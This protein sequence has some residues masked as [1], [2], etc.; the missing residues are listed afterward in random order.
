MWLPFSTAGDDVPMDPSD[1]LIFFSGASRIP[2][3]GFDRECTLS[4]N[5][6][7][8]YPTA[9]TCALE[10]TLPT[11]YHDD[12]IHFKDKMLYAFAN[13]GGFGLC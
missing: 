1:C 7:S 3:I 6:S 11:M 4:F 9:S 10:L 8:V 13:N 12:Y 5:P 2:P